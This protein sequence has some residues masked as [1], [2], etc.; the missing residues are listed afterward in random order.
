[1]GRVYLPADEMTAHGVVP[2]DLAAATASPALK[3][4]LR[5]QA[6]RARDYYRRAEAGIPRLADDGSQLTVWLMRHVYAGILDEIEKL[7]HEVLHSARI[8]VVCAQDRAR[9]AGVAG[10]SASARRGAAFM[11]AARKNFAV[12]LCAAALAG[13]GAAAAIPRGVRVRRGTPAL[14]AARGAGG[15][16]REP[17]ELVGRVRAVRALLAIVAA[18]HLS[19]D[20]GA[21]SAPLPLF[22]VDGRLRD[23]PCRPAIRAAGDALRAAPARSAPGD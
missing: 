15:R 21:K 23:R 1:M 5:A 22:Y 4:L 10:P 14:A 17:H 2:D 13:A 18:R 9:G 8:H 16:L 3:T 20:G 6:S 11:I 19:G 12:Q 7:D